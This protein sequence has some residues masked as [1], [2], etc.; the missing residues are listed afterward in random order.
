MPAVV[1]GLLL[2]VLLA[3]PAQADAMRCGN[4]L[5]TDGDTRSKVQELCGDPTEVQT[6]SILRRPQFWLNG[7][8]YFSGDGFEE[9][10][11]EVWTYNLGPYQLMR[12]IKFVDGLIDQIETLGYGYHDNNN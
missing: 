5:V 1:F 9:V 11:V 2:N 4:R 12:R 6:H 3:A 8:L 10:P 7:R